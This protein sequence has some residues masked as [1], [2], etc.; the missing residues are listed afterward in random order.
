MISR[1]ISL[2]AFLLLAVA[3]SLAGSSFEAG[4]WYYVTMNRPPMAPPGW[5]YAVI[6]AVVYVLMALAAWRVWMT[7]HHSRLAALA[8][9]IVLLLLN[10]GWSMLFFGLN[11]PGW[12]LPLLVLAAGSAV[13]CIRAFSR[14]SGQAAWLMTPYLAWILFILVFNLAVWTV[15]GGALGRFLN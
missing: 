9:W 1:Y 10:T 14:L 11:R 6:W 13:L 3:A 5:L 15:N 4:E 12:A 2:A 8:W 7:R